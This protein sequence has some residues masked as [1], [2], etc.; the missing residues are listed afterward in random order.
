MNLSPHFTLEELTHSDFAT[1]K[2]IDNTPNDDV[3]ACLSLLA[4]G[5]ERV[6]AIL[7][8]PMRINSGYRGPKLN[9]AIGGSKASAHM[10]GLAADFTSKE[11]GSPIDIC[12]MIASH[13]KEVGFDQII[14]EGQWVHIAFPDGTLPKMQVLTAKFMPSGVVYIR[15]LE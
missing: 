1:R 2:N 8:V 3:R 11:F 15:G 5:L 7:G 10:L 4:S 9:A 12:R 6:R 13:A 14:N